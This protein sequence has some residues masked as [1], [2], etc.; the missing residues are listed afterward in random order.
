MHVRWDSWEFANIIRY[1]VTQKYVSFKLNALL[2]CCLLAQSIPDLA[3]FPSF[4]SPPICWNKDTTSSTLE[5]RGFQF[6]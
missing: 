1:Y 4:Q 3:A 5:G 6:S 2:S